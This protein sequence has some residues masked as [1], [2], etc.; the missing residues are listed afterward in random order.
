VTANCMK[1]PSLLLP[2]ERKGEITNGGGARSRLGKRE[3]KKTSQMITRKRLFTPLLRR[4]KKAGG[5]GE[6]QRLK[7]LS[8]K[9][10]KGGFPVRD[11]LYLILIIKGRKLKGFDSRVKC[12]MGQRIT[13]EE[14]GYNWGKVKGWRQGSA[15]EG[16]DPLRRVC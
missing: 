5:G 8:S 7:R 11:E 3:K 15:D 13:G 2:L 12:L 10:K 1:D 14:R 4:H 6:N 16:G 9:E